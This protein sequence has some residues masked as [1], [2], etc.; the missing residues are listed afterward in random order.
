MLKGFLKILTLSLFGTIIV[1]VFN[2]PLNAHLPAV[3]F[4]VCGI[5]FSVGMSQIMTYDI[6]KIIN[7]KYF[8]SIKN[9]L[10]NIRKSFVMQFICCGIAYIGYE[11]LVEQK[12][13]IFTITIK[14]FNFSLIKFLNIMLIC[15]LIYF[16][17][18][19][20]ELLKNKLELDS[21]IRQETL[22]E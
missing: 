18:N 17:I 21:K 2:I 11:I 9:S 7:E 1:A 10:H 14:W 16:I 4:T 13:P 15:C 20:Q 3:L 19:F 6:S 5:F 22:D 12:K 8:Q